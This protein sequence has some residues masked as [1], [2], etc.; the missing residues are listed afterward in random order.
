MS[1]ARDIYLICHFNGHRNLRFGK[2]S[3][4]EK[5]ISTNFDL[6]YEFS[7]HPYLFLTIQM[8]HCINYE[9]YTVSRLK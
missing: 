2:G 9:F 1:D 8:I 6:L 5:R 3:H 7:L 4:H